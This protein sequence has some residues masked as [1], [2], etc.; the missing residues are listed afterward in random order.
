[1]FF[2][3]KID[4]SLK[5]SNRVVL[6]GNAPIETDIYGRK[7]LSGFVDD[8]EVVIRINSADNY[9]NGT[10]EKSDILG[11]INSGD[12]AIEFSYRKEVN[13]CVKEKISSVWF[14]R[15]LNLY[16]NSNLL[17]QKELF[18]YVLNFQQLN[19]I[20]FHAISKEQYL[21]LSKQVS[22]I[23]GNSIHPSSGLCLLHMMLSDEK[24]KGLKKIIVGFTWEGW[25]GH[26]WGIEK[27]IC[28]DLRNNGDIFIL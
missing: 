13:K 24:L 11:I 22:P 14:S 10:G 20:P 23:D 17:V 2:G 7:G 15:P 18:K 28:L 3:K 25:D 9:A 12:P 26:N 4:S 19:H 1:M 5:D 8:S 6:I 21:Y 27:K 16:E